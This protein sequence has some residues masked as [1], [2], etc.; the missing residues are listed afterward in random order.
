MREATGRVAG[1]LAILQL[2]AVTQ[3][4]NLE[5]QPVQTASTTAKHDDDDDDGGGGGGESIGMKA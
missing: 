2:R 3:E 5:N 1:P 4:T